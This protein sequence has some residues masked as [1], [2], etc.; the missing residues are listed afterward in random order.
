MKTYV[1]L[2]DV[3][4]KTRAIYI[5]GS[6]FAGKRQSGIAYATENYIIAL[7]ELLNDKE[8]VRVLLPKGSYVTARLKNNSAVRLIHM[9][10]GVRLI[11]LLSRLPFTPP[12]DLF[13]GRGLYIFSNYFNLSL[14]GSES[15]T[16]IHDVAFLLFPESVQ[17]RN[18]A[19]L[20]DNIARWLRRTDQV[21]TLSESSKREIVQELGVD[22]SKITVVYVPLYLDRFKRVTDERIRREFRKKYQLPDRYLLYL[23]NLEP[24]K[25]VVSLIRAFTES[26]APITGISLVL[27]GAD[28]WS[29]EDINNAITNAHS[30]GVNVIQPSGHV[31]DN[32]LP[33]L[34]SCAECLVQPSLHEGFGL[35]PVQALACGTP[36]IVSDIPV[37][38]EVLRGCASYFDPHDVLDMTNAINLQLGK[39]SNNINK[40][41][42]S[43]ILGRF[44]PHNIARQIVDLVDKEK[45]GS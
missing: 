31:S 18:R 36:V 28:S 3:S 17:K 27:V 33:T 21:L 14:Y 1:K 40:V 30:S 16:F 41:F 15:A 45:I 5:E 43:E 4:L 11:R 44:D 35:P 22:S 8:P 34:L 29:N 12:L 42:V 20:S 2:D 7:S 24:R 32:D 37:M 6:V 19:F 23:G 38:H 39:K 26:S 10:I 9:P 25:N 13:Y